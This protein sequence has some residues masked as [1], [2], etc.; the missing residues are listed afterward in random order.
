MKEEKKDAEWE[1]ADY[2]DM[3]SDDAASELDPEDIK[4]VEIVEKEYVM[5]EAEAT[6]SSGFSIVEKPDSD[7]HDSSIKSL[8]SI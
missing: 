8:S 5:A 6:S 2:E 4:I 7:K 3:G 1:D